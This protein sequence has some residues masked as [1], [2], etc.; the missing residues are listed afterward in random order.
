MA[1]KTLKKFKMAIGVCGPVVMYTPVYKAY[2]AEEAAEKYL[3]DIKEEPTEDRRKEVAGRMHEIEEK[4]PLEVY[5]DCMGRELGEGDDIVA[6]VKTDRNHSVIGRAKVS[7]LT[8]HGIKIMYNGKEYPIY[9]RDNDFIEVNG[10]EVLCFART[11]KV[12]D[13]LVLEGDL[14]VGDKVAFMKKEYMGTSAG[15]LF[16]SVEEIGDKYIHI[17]TGAEVVKKTH[18]KIQKL[19]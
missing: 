11:I 6:I 19:S 17:N 13:E 12:T 18:G 8:K 5:Y 1:K 9:P 10:E 7:K 16:G 15:F 3:E 2:T 14:K 4:Q